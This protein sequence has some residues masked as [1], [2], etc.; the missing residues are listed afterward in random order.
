[1]HSLAQQLLDASQFGPHAL[2]FRAYLPLF[3]PALFGIASELNQA[4]FIRVELQPKLPQ[5]V[6]EFPRLRIEWV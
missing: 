1:M 5:P 2:R 3:C 4:R 6:P